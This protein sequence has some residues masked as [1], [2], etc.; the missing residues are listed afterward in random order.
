MV[1]QPWLPEVDAGAVRAGCHGFIA[2]MPRH[3]AQGELR[4]PGALETQQ[5][6]CADRNYAGVPPATRRAFQTVERLRG[7]FQQA[8][9]GLTP[10]LRGR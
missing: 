9:P 1:R 6:V 10:A 4:A 5:I 8:F 7:F 2:E 3:D